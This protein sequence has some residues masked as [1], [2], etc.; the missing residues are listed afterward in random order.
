[1]WVVVVYKQ[2]EKLVQRENP[3]K[4]EEEG[5]HQNMTEFQVGPN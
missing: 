5:C 3:I 4:E 2:V 1:M